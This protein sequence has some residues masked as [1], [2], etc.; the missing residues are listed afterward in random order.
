MGTV[1]SLVLHLNPLQEALQPEG[2]GN[3]A[4]LVPRIAEV[5]RGLDVPVIVKEIGMGLSGRVGAMLLDAGVSI[6]DTAGLGGTSWARIEAQRAEDVPLGE[7]FAEWGVATPESIRQLRALP[8]ATV[9]G[10]GGVRNGMDVAKAIAMGADM[11]GLA[12]PFLKA[13]LE[14]A[15]AVVEQIE[16]TLRELRICMFCVGARDLAALRNVPLLERRATS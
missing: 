15:D 13:A 12:Y 14:S 2:D 10:S 9:I 16:R 3:F 11:V 1:S 4:A 7:L 5:V 6:L 8:G